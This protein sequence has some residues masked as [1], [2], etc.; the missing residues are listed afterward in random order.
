MN[1]CLPASTFSETLG[2]VVGFEKQQRTLW[3]L[4]IIIFSFF[5][6]CGPEKKRKIHR[7]NNNDDD[8]GK[9]ALALAVCRLYVHSSHS[10][11]FLLSR[12]RNERRQK[13]ELLC[14]W[15]FRV[16]I[17]FI[18]SSSSCFPRYSFSF[19][20]KHIREEVPCMERHRRFLR[21]TQ[22]SRRAFESRRRWE[23]QTDKKC[24]Y[25]SRR[26]LNRRVRSEDYQ[27]PSSSVLVSHK[28]HSELI[29]ER[30]ATISERGR[31][32]LRW[33]SKSCNHFRWWKAIT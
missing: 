19:R 8:D 20:H 7:I 33:T 16:I 15:G 32:T 24:F 9:W 10:Q 25:D 11:S 1:F 30:F 5:L 2:R 21:L 4:G 26:G 6:L 31:C 18:K 22:D 3:C 27:A 17:I 29:W 12:K 23:R 13:L 28:F 14:S